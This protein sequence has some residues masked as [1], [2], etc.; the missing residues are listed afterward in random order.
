MKGSHSNAVEQVYWT[1][2]YFLSVLGAASALAAALLERT[3]TKRASE[4]ALRRVAYALAFLSIESKG[5]VSNLGV[6]ALMAN[7]SR[8][9]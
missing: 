3:P 1:N 6:G 8:C 9:C 5:T 2:V 4:R 7:T